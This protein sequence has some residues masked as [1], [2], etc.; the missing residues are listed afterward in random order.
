M[1]AFQSFRMHRTSRTHHP[2]SPRPIS[3]LQAS[4]TAETQST[5][6]RMSIKLYTSPVLNQQHWVIRS[7]IIRK[8]KKTT[9]APGLTTQQLWG[10]VGSLSSRWWLHRWISG[11]TCKLEAITF[12]SPDM[13]HTIAMNLW[14]MSKVK[15]TPFAPVA[16]SWPCHVALLYGWTGLYWNHRELESSPESM[17]AGRNKWQRVKQCKTPIHYIFIKPEVKSSWSSWSSWL[18]V[19]VIV[20]IVVI[21]PTLNHS[22]FDIYDFCILLQSRI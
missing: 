18:S 3:H 2:I 17:F 12:F 15:M 5:S 11:L 13:Q 6:P 9:C 7:K 4:L 10:P 14:V 16:A 1:P 19:I 8:Y 22:Y 20:V 21:H